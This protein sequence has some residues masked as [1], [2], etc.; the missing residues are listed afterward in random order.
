MGT[1][2]RSN[3]QGRSCEALVGE[4]EELA[5]R[6]YSACSGFA[7]DVTLRRSLPALEAGIAAGAIDSPSTLSRLNA[8]YFGL[9]TG[10]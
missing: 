7:F 5:G 4:K 8:Q 2:I 3:G 9:Y 6:N 10:S 1:G